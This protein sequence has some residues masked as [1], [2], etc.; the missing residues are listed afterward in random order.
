MPFCKQEY[1]IL[2]K[3]MGR[4]EEAFFTW[5]ILIYV[6]I[7]LNI[8][9]MI[10]AIQMVKNKLIR[11][12]LL[13][14]ATPLLALYIILT[15]E[16]ISVPRCV[17]LCFI[18]LLAFIDLP[19]FDLR[20]G[21]V[22][23]IMVFIIDC[24]MQNYYYVYTDSFSWQ[25]RA[26]T[27]IILFMI[28][29][30]ISYT[31]QKWLYKLFCN[32]LL[33]IGFINFIVLSVTNKAVRLSDIRLISTALG[34]IKGVQ[35]P[36]SKYLL[37]IISIIMIIFFNF[38]LSRLHIEFKKNGKRIIIC[39]A[40]AFVFIL[41]IR[42][43]SGGYLQY[44]GNTRYGVLINMLIEEDGYQIKYEDEFDPALAPED[45]VGQTG[46]FDQLSQDEK[47]N[48]IVILSEAYAD[49]NT[50]KDFPTDTQY[51]PYAKEI[52]KSCGGYAY[53]SVFGNNTVS[54]EF[55]VLTGIPTGLTTSGA[56]LY[57]KI[58]PM[59]SLVSLFKEKGYYTVGIHP[60][61]ANGYNRNKAWECFGFDKTIFDEEF[62]DAESFAPE[63][64]HFPTDRTLFE[65]V[66]D[67]IDD[68]VP[69]FTFVITMQTHATYDYNMQQN[70]HV[71][72][73]HGKEMDNYLSLENYS[74]EALK[75]LIEKLNEKDR[76][77]YILF[78][79][80]HQPLLGF[81]NYE[82]LMDIKSIQ[83]LDDEKNRQMY[84]VPYFI[85]TN[86]D[87]KYSVPEE[88]SM[89][90]LPGIL[91][92]ILGIR[93]SWYEYTQK[94]S[95]IFPVITDSFFK[96]NDEWIQESPKRTIKEVHNDGSDLSQLKQYQVYTKNRI[97][98]GQNEM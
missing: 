3:H 46:E 23:F 89:N 34:V 43:N 68:D 2:K 10:V 25:A 27:I 58:K 67:E 90:Y 24:V 79:G 48:V 8:Q 15:E 7:P 62:K 73:Y 80:D 95:Q 20:H 17:V 78:F 91:L 44:Y 5:L 72:D 26:V 86:S 11:R 6:N 50:Y 97:N 69:I 14:I 21:L 81:E 45:T 47:P 96:W 92:D 76:D 30:G 61:L 56:A 28:L 1:E 16:Y 82:Y 57:D 29:L 52:I 88:T 18:I 63:G 84:N 40:I 93:D 51:I 13:I 60:Y 22:A 31:E 37:L 70:I 49:F 12:C 39:L 54:T 87:K 36:K 71:E 94:I 85:W 42:M 55:S 66:V 65:K 32:F 9:W 75:M 74:D 98:S 35:F 19:K 41:N 33:I 83:E 77:T 4:V 59:P 38:M 64:Y 53:S